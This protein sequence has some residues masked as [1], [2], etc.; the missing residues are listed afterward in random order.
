[1]MDTLK[2]EDAPKFHATD[3]PTRIARILA[4]EKGVAVG[5]AYYG[6]GMKVLCHTH[7]G[8]EYIHVIGGTGIFRTRDKEVVARAG[9]TLT[10]EPGE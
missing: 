7:V 10:L 3:Q 9:T 1:M 6:K 2:I 8:D 4:K 5:R